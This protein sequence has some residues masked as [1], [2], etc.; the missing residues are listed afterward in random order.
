LQ[1][2][3]K[4]NGSAERFLYF[5]RKAADEIR[6]SVTF[7]TGRDVVNDELQTRGLQG[8]IINQKLTIVVIT[9]KITRQITQIILCVKPN[10]IWIL[11]WI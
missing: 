3:V 10:S 4:Q 6:I 5:G 7:S 1:S 8:F 9:V 11:I 2:Y